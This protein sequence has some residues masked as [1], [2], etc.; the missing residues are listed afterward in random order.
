M[1]ID[2]LL[3]RRDAAQ[4]IREREIPLEPSTLA[5]YATVGGG[6]NMRKF[7]RRVLYE[8]RALIAWIAEKLGASRRCTSD[9]TD[10][11]HGGDIS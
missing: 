10:S 7:G 1:S 3:S 4:F 5:K 6:P 11:R 2:Q 9:G 8:R